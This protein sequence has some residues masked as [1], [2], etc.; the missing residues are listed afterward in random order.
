[1]LRRTIGVFAFALLACSDSTGPSGLNGT[2]TFTFGGQ[3]FTIT[4]SAPATGT[5]PGPN[6]NVVAGNIDV[7][8]NQTIAI[9]M[10]LSGGEASDFVVIGINRSTVGSTSIEAECDPEADTCTGMV[11]FQNASGTGTAASLV[12]GL[13][14]GTVEI[15]EVT[16]SRIKGTFS[17]T[18]ECYDESLD[19]ISAFN[20]TAGSFNVA[21]VAEAFAAPNR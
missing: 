9:A 1:M 15:T 18:G 20:V 19:D 17:G 7:G 8:L 5:E 14:S 3:V 12:C 13:I 21:L 16:G 4:G 10:K 11:Y 6:A 2:I